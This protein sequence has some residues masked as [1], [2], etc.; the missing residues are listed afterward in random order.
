MRRD[1]QY[2]LTQELEDNLVKLLYAVNKFRI[3]YGKPMTVS[4][5]YRPGPFNKSA[6]GAPNSSHIT[7]EAVDFSDNDG[8]L[9]AWIA[10]N[11]SIL[12]DC[13]L[14]MED[15]GHTKTWVHLTTR[16]P[17]SGRRVFLP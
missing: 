12:D 7:C 13:D 4:S 10:N 15:P 11:L 6:G 14:Y 9:K 2:P 3:A 5:G 16:A 17:H 1:T 8:T